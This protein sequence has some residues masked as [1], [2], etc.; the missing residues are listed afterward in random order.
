MFYYL[1][2]NVALTDG[3]IAVIDVGG[4]GYKCHVTAAT[5]ARVLPGK[6]AK[7]YTYCNIREDAF[8]IFGFYTTE[9]KRCFEL[10]LT[11]SGIGPKAALSILSSCTP[12]ALAVAVVSDDVSALTSTPGVGKKLAQRIILELKDKVTRE[13]EILRAEGLAAPSP[14]GG[15]FEAHAAL[16][17]LGYTNAEITALMRRLKTD[18]MTT[19]EIVREALK[20]SLKK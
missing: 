7:L 16:S 13:A 20:Q 15:A 17:V 4:A 6:R 14:E 10:L 12:E 1:E 11:V 8:D 3:N 2:G 19:E 18:S 5:L 9:E